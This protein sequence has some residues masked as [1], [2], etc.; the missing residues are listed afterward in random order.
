MSYLL[1]ASSNFS[2]PLWNSSTAARASAHACST[3]ASVVISVPPTAR[4]TD[5]FA[6]PFARF[7]LTFVALAARTVES[8]LPPQI[9]CP[10]GSPNSAAP[11]LFNTEAVR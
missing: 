7:A 9:V 8:S 10:D 2:K 11:N 3:R 5:S 6:L 1:S 4:A